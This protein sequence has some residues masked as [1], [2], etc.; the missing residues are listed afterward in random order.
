MRRLRGFVV[1][2]ARRGWAGGSDDP[3][4]IIESDPEN[5]TRRRLVKINPNQHR[6]E[7]AGG[8]CPAPPR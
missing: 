2:A 3:S 6:I 5:N 1:L 8:G 7:L 4:Q